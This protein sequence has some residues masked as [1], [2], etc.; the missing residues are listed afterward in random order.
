MVSVTPGPE[1]YCDWLYLEASIG[2]L[3]LLMVKEFS[4]TSRDGFC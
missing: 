4:R 2:T 3:L 1:Y